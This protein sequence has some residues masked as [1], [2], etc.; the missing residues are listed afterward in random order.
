MYRAVIL[1]TCA[2][3]YRRMDSRLRENDWLV[4]IELYVQIGVVG[5]YGGSRARLRRG[6]LS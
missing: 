5:G 4:R 3:C 1:Q 6:Q 2:T